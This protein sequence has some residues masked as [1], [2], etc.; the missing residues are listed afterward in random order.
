MLGY[1]VVSRRAS[2]CG[3]KQYPVQESRQECLSGSSESNQFQ[4]TRGGSMSLTD[5]REQDASC[6]KRSVLSDVRRITQK[7]GAGGSGI[8][9]VEHTDGTETIL[10]FDTIS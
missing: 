1:K 7:R 10:V 6:S 8:V 2:D 5:N 3:D 4:A 9:E